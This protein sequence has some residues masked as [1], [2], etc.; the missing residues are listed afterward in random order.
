MPG[1]RIPGVSGALYPDEASPRNQKMHATRMARP[2]QDV[3]NVPLGSIN[4]ACPTTAA[5]Q[6]GAFKG[7]QINPAAPY[8]PQHPA[9][10]QEPSLEQLEAWQAST[11]ELHR[12]GDE[13]RASYNWCC[14]VKNSF[15]HVRCSNGEGGYEDEND[16]GSSQRSSSVPSRI[17]HDQQEG[18]ESKEFPSFEEFHAKRAQNLEFCPGKGGK[19]SE[20]GHYWKGGREAPKGESGKKGRGEGKRTLP[21]THILTANADLITPP[22]APPVRGGA[23]PS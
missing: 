9:H 4:E 13:D 15:L 18:T 2:A 7:Y 10:T 20:S 17:S 12:G 16:D 5:Q 3:V 19:G 6:Q 14:S 1:Y 8:I 23:G 11:G 22:I 21:I